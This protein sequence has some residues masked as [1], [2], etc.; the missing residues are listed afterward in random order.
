MKHD[1]LNNWQ[2]DHTFNQDQRKPGESRTIVVILITAIMMV[3]EIAAGLNF[4]SMALLAD[5]LHMG[6]HT[7][8][9]G[10]TAFAYIY[11]RR[12]AQN[13]KFS[14]GTG[15]VNALGG[16]TGAVLLVIF[17]LL[18]GY[19]S[20]ERFFNPVA[21][22]Y[23]HAIIV[24]VIGLIVNGVCVVILHQSDIQHSHEDNHRHTLNQDH[25]LKSAYL[26]VMTDAL[27]SLLAIFA[28]ISAKYIQWLWMDPAVGILG[29]MLVAR[30]SYYLVKTTASVLLDHQAPQHIQELV[31]NA[32]E[33]DGLSRITDLHIWSIG[34][35]MYS[36]Q[37]TLV[38]P[39]PASAIEYKKRIPSTAKLV[40]ITIEIQ[41]N[42]PVS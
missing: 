28:L 4:G 26:H 13:K 9:L 30:W 39:H 6:S 17:A 15:K 27:T 40:H 2:H 34:P 11:A 19:E 38:S 7:V 25:N 8:A 5:G 41:E 24:A 18:M 35:E 32:V 3:V 21:I 42:K 23:D 20:I 1:N 22:S 16:F 12:H 36:A 37:I 14:F 31:T 29:A 33:K 10:I